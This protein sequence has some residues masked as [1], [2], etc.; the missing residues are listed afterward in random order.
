MTL[1]F[2]IWRLA[3]VLVVAAAIGCSFCLYRISFAKA[4]PSLP[5]ATILI[6]A[7]TSLITGLQF[8]FPEILSDFRRNREALRAGEW[9][10]MVTPLFVQAAGW[11]QCCVNGVGAFL[12]CPLAERLYG[13][14]LFALY[15][16]P[17]VLGEISAY[18]WSPTGAGSSLGL[19]GVLGSLLAFIFLH[20]QEMPWCAR[21]LAIFGF[22][23]A[24]ALSFC[25][26]NHGPP[27]LIGILLAG[28][29]TMLWPNKTV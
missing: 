12:L 1:E 15:F 3:R 18:A 25:R 19:A 26:D 21:L 20:R 7:V 11:K 27:I 6:I 4:K 13:K 5:I 23:G 17:G 22:A 16:I 14:R 29:M 10:R 9:W 24:V 2:F 28:V 8:V